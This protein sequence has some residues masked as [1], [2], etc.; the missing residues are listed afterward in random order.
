MSHQSRDIQGLLPTLLALA[1]L[2]VGLVWIWLVPAL[3]AFSDW[4]V[5][6]A[7]LRRYEQQ[8]ERI[9]LDQ[10][11]VSRPSERAFVSGE[12]S[13][14]EALARERLVELIANAAEVSSL[15]VNTSAPSVD[16]QKFGRGSSVLRVAGD[17]RAV[18]ALLLGLATINDQLEI[19]GF[20][21]ADIGSHP[22]AE[23]TG[24]I[25]LSWVWAVPDFEAEFD[26]NP[27]IAWHEEAG[28][29]EVP[30]L[31]WATRSPF[32]PEHRTY[33]PLA[34]PPP[35]PQVELLG[36]TRQD[37]QFIATLQIDGT[38]FRVNE[39]SMTPAGPVVAIS[40]DRIELGGEPPRVISLFD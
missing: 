22:G 6:R 1:A 8:L 4:Q 13:D 12:R 9:R 7:E 31:G 15:D 30:G 17:V 37:G 2:V 18:E 29:E 20:E 32:D 21:F 26:E 36:I 19:R 23:M 34:P 11:Y 5:S 28:S 3:L 10:R 16:G 14:I 39:G 24:E 25:R 38:E 40:I 35:V 27:A 33:A